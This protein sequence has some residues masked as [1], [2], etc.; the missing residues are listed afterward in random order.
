[1]LADYKGWAH[2]EPIAGGKETQ[3]AIDAGIVPPPTKCNRC[4]QTEGVI[5]YH[6]EDYSDPI[7][8]FEPLCFI[9]SCAQERSDTLSQDFE[10]RAES[11]RCAVSA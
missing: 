11:C 2:K 5:V 6:N 3:K 9:P 4:V 10:Q 8:H 1:M 7:K